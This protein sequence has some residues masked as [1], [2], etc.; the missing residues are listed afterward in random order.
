MRGF[1]EPGTYFV[2]LK[3]GEECVG[4]K[5]E[6]RAEELA[7]ELGSAV[8]IDGDSD[9]VLVAGIYFLNYPE[10]MCVWLQEIATG[11]NAVLQPTDACKGVESRV[12]G[13]T[14]VVVEGVDKSRIGGAFGD[15]DAH[16]LADV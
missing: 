7:K 10:D 6:S 16:G 9:R 4:V 15:V 14:A 2:G 8:F 3:K 11:F 1:V 13:D 12:V 5:S